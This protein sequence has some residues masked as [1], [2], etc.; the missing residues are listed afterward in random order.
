MIP[1]KVGY[2]AQGTTTGAQI[3]NGP[4]T[5]YGVIST[6]T[7]GSCVIYDGTSSSDPVLFS[8]TLAVGDAVTFGGVGIAANKGLFVVVTGTV[9]ILY[10]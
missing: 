1:A 10:V 6:V 4:S 7:G 2:K 3:K 9:N 8:K 5:F